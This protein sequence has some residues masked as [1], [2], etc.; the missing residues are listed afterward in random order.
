MMAISSTDVEIIV[1]LHA[2][3]NCDSAKVSSWLSESN[4]NFGMTMPITM[5][6]C[7]QS[8]KLLDW[9]ESRLYADKPLSEVD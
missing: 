5:M 8:Q 2:S 7:G 1:N 9:I 4:P 3:F 6:S